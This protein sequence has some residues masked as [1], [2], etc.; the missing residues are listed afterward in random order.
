MNEAAVTFMD[1]WLGA[2]VNHK[3][4]KK[5]TARTITALARRCIADASLAGISLESIE[6]VVGDIETAIVDELNFIA[7]LKAKGS[8]Q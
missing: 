1:G 6:E 7:A 2:N 4:A 5:P 8:M 3:H